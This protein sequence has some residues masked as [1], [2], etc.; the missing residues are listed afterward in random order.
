MYRMPEDALGS[1]P[2]FDPDISIYQDIHKFEN[3]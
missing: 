3:G 1:Y 2:H